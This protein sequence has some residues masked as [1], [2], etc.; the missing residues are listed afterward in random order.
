MISKVA[1][2][3]LAIL[4]VFSG[5]ALAQTTA[6]AGGSQ[7]AAPPNA[8][9]ATPTAP[10]VTTA[11]A[12]GTRVGTINIEQAI[13]ACNEGRKEFDVLM[14]KF[15]PKQN[16]LKTMNDEIESLQKQLNTQGDKMNQ[17]AHDNLVKQI[18]AK[19]KSFD[20][21]QQDAREE[22]QS[23]QN[24]IAQRILQKMVPVVQ[25]YVI[26]NGYGLLLDTSQPWP[27]GPV[28]MAGP[29]IDITGPIVEAYNAQSGVPAPAGGTTAKPGAV[30]PAVSPTKPAGTATK[31]PASN[32]PASNPP[33]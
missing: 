15:E 14:K 18:E 7:A 11:V 21:A 2:I 28:I 20:R 31:P 12:L 17:D 27:Q 9:S 24:E 32:P 26:D 6:A 5:F 3:S 33:K 13:A 25:K 30:K 16:E 22:F 19:R 10:P 8:P 23:Q 29:S 4:V 1:R